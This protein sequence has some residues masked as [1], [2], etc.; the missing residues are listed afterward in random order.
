[1]K[2]TLSFSP[3]EGDGERITVDEVRARIGQR[4]QQGINEERLL[5]VL[6]ALPAPSRS[7]NPDRRR[8]KADGGRAEE[9]SFFHVHIA[10]GQAVSLRADGRADF[11]RQDR[12]IGSRGECTLHREDSQSC[13][14]R[15]MG[16]DGYSDSA[17]SGGAGDAEAAAVREDVQTDAASA[18]PLKSDGSSCG[19][20]ASWLSWMRTPCMATWTCPRGNVNFPGIVH[21]TGS[22]RSG[23]TVVAEGVLEVGEAWREPALLGRHHPVVEGIKGEGKAILLRQEGHRERLCGAG[24]SAGHR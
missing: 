15:W 14:R 21:V 13:G 10:T 20:A 12:I 23:F 7:R 4:C 16:R 2:A 24:G 19:T 11:R 6:T 17:A 8:Q 3:P 5:S 1:M 9:D 22:I 18:S